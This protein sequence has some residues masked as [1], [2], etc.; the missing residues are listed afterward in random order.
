M[1]IDDEAQHPADQGNT[2]KP[3]DTRSWYEDTHNGPGETP[4]HDT[5]TLHQEQTKDTAVEVDELE[6]ART[7]ARVM[8]AVNNA[9]GGNTTD[10]HLHPRE[11]YTK[12]PMPNI[13]D[14]NPATLL[15]G[16]D[17]T[18]IQSWLSLPTGK[19]LARPFNTDVDYQPNHQEI[20]RLLLEATKEITGATTAEVASPN[21]DKS[22]PPGRKNLRPRTFLIHNLTR[23]EADTLLERKIWSSKVITFQAAP[24]N[25]RRPEFLFTIG[26][27]STDNKDHV[28]E[29]I[30]NTWDD[31][32]TRTLLR[33]IAI[34]APDVDEQQERMLQ[35]LEFLE[36]A[37]VTSLEIRSA[38]GRPDP[39]FNVYT[40]RE[41]IEDDDA[42]LELRKYLKSCTYRST[43]YGTGK[44]KMEDFTCSLCHGH[45][46]PRGMCPFPHLQGWNRGG[47]NPKKLLDTGRPLNADNRRG[48]RTMPNARP[49]GSRVPR[50]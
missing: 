37:T 23:K 48:G 2:P 1:A 27:F 17:Q 6:N 5:N 8:A 33:S 35:M 30:V 11:K 13:Y 36:S 20:A 19:V 22:M 9:V 39:H 24:V 42:W 31:P 15:T 38:G 43:L 26:G 41:I 21:R 34:R 40:D 29:T 50:A 44:A 10:I 4:Y 16:V 18:Q 45:D 47:R 12:D 32:V 3:G 25:V 28:T 14:G 46:H 49:R 7:L